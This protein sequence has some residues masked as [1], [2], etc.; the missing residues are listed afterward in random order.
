MG[1]RRLEVGAAAAARGSSDGPRQE[2]RRGP[3]TGAAAAVLAW[4][5]GDRRTTCGYATNGIERCG[6]GGHKI[7][8]GMA[9]EPPTEAIG[10]HNI[11]S[12][13]GFEAGVAGFGA[14]AAAELERGGRRRWPHER[15]R[16]LLRA[17]E[18]REASSRG[19]TATGGPRGGAARRREEWSAQRRENRGRKKGICL[20]ANPATGRRLGSDGG[21]PDPAMAA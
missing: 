3:E 15:Q 7:C 6:T 16:E 2:R 8:G 1:R 19:G 11:G 21:G 4:N 20:E 17:R 9:K 13:S 12:R 18:P 10:R 5:K 14:G